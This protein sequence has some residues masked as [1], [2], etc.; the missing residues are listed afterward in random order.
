MEDGFGQ[1][2][3]GCVS[4]ISTVTGWLG[5][6]SRRACMDGMIMD[7]AYRPYVNELLLRLPDVTLRGLQM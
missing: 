2:V 5:F 4:W 1:C 6:L 7:V 3:E